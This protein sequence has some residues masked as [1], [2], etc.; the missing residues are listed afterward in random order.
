MMIKRNDLRMGQLIKISKSKNRIKNILEGQ[1][2]KSEFDDLLV[3]TGIKVVTHVTET[4]F[5]VHD[6]A[7]DIAQ[8]YRMPEGSECVL[9]PVFWEVE[10]LGE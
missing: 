7:Y 5:K 8:E 10:I 1:P 2:D 6:I 4:T 3:E 9:H